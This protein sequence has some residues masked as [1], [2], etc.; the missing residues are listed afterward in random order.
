MFSA[1]HDNTLDLPDDLRMGDHNGGN[2]RERALRNDGQ[3]FVP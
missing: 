3:P 1:N 2:V